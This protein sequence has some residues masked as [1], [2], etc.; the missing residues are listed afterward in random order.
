MKLIEYNAVTINRIKKNT[1]LLQY[2][3]ILMKLIEY[4]VVT[5]NRIQ[6]CYY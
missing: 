4:N 5:I 1:I 6:Y 2:N 3:T